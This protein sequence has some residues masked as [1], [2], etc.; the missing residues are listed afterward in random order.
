METVKYQARLTS[1]VK[2]TVY[3]CY[4]KVDTKDTDILASIY[5]HFSV[6]Q[7]GYWFS[8]LYKQGRWDG[9]RHFFSRV[10]RKL[11]T[12]LLPELENFLERPYTFLDKRKPL[13]KVKAVTKLGEYDLTSK[14]FSYQGEAV[15]ECLAAGRGVLDLATN[16]GKT[17][18]AAAIIKSLNL[19]TLFVAGTK[20]IVLQTEEVFERVLERE[21]SVLGAG[22]K[23]LGYI[24]VCTAQ[25]LI[26]LVKGKMKELSHFEVIFFDETHHSS[27]DTWY[28]IALS[29]PARYRFGLSGTAFAGKNDKDWRLIGATGP[30][31]KHVSNA[32]LIERGVSAKPNVVFVEAEV[33]EPVSGDYL[34]VVK[35]GIVNDVVRNCQI[36]AMSFALLKRDQNVL[37]L[38]P[39][40]VHGLNLFNMIRQHDDKFNV[41]FNHGSLH[42]HA[43]KKNLEK[44]KEEG[45]VMIA[46]TIYDEGVDIPQINA[47]ILAFGGKSKRKV[48]QRIGRAL[49]RKIDGENVV[50]IYDFWDH[51]NEYLERHSRGRLNL[52]LGEGFEVTG[53]ND[54]VEQWVESNKKRQ[55]REL[56][57]RKPLKVGNTTEVSIK[58]VSR[59][60]LIRRKLRRFQERKVG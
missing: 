34:T 14:A 10:T 55:N 44:F 5:R 28:K 17:I 1:M 46:T 15:Q 29:I 59:Q 47:L 6:P 35:E 3:N 54:R 2:V 20:D 58:R 60:D 52:Y 8:P 9:K 13:K 49:R 30:L 36:H 22:R 41:F 53:A 50:T 12:G 4:I 21:I 38:T 27:S 33:K 7:E 11:P 18:V 39:R 25:S 24:T 37:I 45:G 57:G 43:R 56:T 40:K 32:E 23:E 26:R 48:L 31:I 19:P 16:S 42:A 51:H